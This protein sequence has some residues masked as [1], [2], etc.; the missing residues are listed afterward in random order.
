MNFTLGYLEIILG[1]MFSG[2]TTELMR[3]SNRYKHSN[4]KCCII[5]HSLDDNRYN[6]NNH[7]VSHNKYKV[8]CIYT[9]SLKNSCKHEKLRERVDSLMEKLQSQLSVGF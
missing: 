8:P 4:I 2:K 7:M 6:D 5:N 1:P 3:I 9:N